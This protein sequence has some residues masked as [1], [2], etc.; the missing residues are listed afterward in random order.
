MVVLE[1]TAAVMTTGMRSEKEKEDGLR[2]G[3]LQ[4]MA[5]LGKV[6]PV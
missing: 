1:V 2:N 3:H 4:T 5:D 6:K